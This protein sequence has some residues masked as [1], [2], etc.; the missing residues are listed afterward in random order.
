MQGE[1]IRD[2]KDGMKIFAD[3]LPDASVIG[4]Q[5]YNAPG[6][7]S[8]QGYTELVPISKVS[9]VR[10]NIDTAIENMSASGLTHSKDAMTFPKQKLEEGKSRYP[11]YKLNLV[12]IS[13][14]VPQTDATHKALCPATPLP[15]VCSISGLS[16]RCFAES[17]DPT[18][19]ASEIKASGVRIFTIAY[20]DDSD[21]KFNNLLQNL[22]K[23]VA[24]SP[25]DYYLAPVSN[26]ID[27]ILAQIGQKVC[28]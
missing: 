1:K 19:V 14:G 26:Q 22:M 4:I 21:A 18:G 15:E 10:S 7:I 2:L 20:I 28:N 8:P 9:D 24:S 25:E 16:C 3:K 6:N 13:D 17:Q 5:A 12:F 27:G 23:N 11:E